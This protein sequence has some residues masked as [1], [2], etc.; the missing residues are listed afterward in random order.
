MERIGDPEAHRRGVITWLASYPK[1][2]S[3]WA[4]ML[5]TA[6]HNDGHLDIN[7]T[8]TTGDV[9]IQWYQSASVIPVP[10]MSQKARVL[11]RYA[12]L[13]NMI[14]CTRHRPL[15]AKTHHA[16]AELYGVRLIPP[17][18]T[19]RAIYIVRDPRD[20]APS[21]AR[22]MGKTVDEAI[23]DMADPNHAIGSD[24]EVPH[25]LTTWSDHVK[26]WG[27]G[28]PE[29]VL[30]RYEDLVLDAAD[31]LERMLV[32]CNVRP[33]QSRIYRAVEACEVE[34]LAEQEAA[35]GFSERS[36]QCERFFGAGKGW[37]NELT[38]EQV[39]RIESDH[40]EMMA[41]MGYGVTAS[42]AA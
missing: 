3:T 7:D 25:L 28:D 35:I 39:A 8:V 41:K 16:N 31:A 22:H 21:L 6:Y 11:L 20:V 24:Q 37:R 36:K 29:V 32:T 4:R 38:P 30:V 18:L 40:G 9:A 26:S 10:R 12:A 34:R 42:E 2:G 23:G 17:Q 27:A 14:A 19:S 33:K 15:V 1:S 13:L 5:L